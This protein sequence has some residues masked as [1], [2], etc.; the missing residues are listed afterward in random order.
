MPGKRSYRKRRAPRRITYGQIGSKIYADV[1]R[2]KRLVN[3]EFKHIDAASSATTANP[4]GGLGPIPLS[5]ISIGDTNVTRDGNSVKAQYLSV[6]CSA[7]INQTTAEDVN[8]R[9]VLVKASFGENITP[10]LSDI[11][12]DGTAFQ[13]FRNVNQSL[14]YKILWDKT[15][16][17]SAAGKAKSLVQ[18]NGKLSHHLKFD[19]SAGTDHTYGQLWLFTFDDATTNHPTLIV[20]S[21]MR[22]TDN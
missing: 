4:S 19:G 8:L 12:D 21:R 22:F 11:L 13:D 5:P 9:Y 16:S 6:R 2:L 14:G 10:I 7:E 15:V 17:L 3:V 1:K 18:F 20:Q